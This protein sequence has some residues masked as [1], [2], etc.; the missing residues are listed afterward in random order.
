MGIFIDKVD[1]YCDGCD[2]DAK[3]ELDNIDFNTG[4]DR[5]S[6]LA[7]MIADKIMNWEVEWWEK[8]VGNTS[9]IVS[10]TYCPNC[11][12]RQEELKRRKEELE[13]VIQKLERED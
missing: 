9:Y 8:V 11:L 5:I 6:N 10:K 1:V 12:D 3:V 4:I 2:C 7:D 13:E